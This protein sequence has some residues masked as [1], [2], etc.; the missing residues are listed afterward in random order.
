MGIF[1]RAQSA[2]FF[3]SCIGSCASP[4]AA[5]AFALADLLPEPKR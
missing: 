3:G 2:L 1:D 4:G 5:P